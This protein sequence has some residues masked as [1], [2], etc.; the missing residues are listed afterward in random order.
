MDTCYRTAQPGPSRS[1][2]WSGTPLCQQLAGSR[3]DLSALSLSFVQM[4]KL[5]SSEGW[6]LPGRLPGQTVQC[7]T[8]ESLTSFFL[9]G[10]I[11]I[12]Q[13]TK[14]LSGAETITYCSIG[15]TNARNVFCFHITVS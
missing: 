9:R 7:E 4:E 11:E 5:R 1:L 2:T 15:T 14:F 8:L 6:D 13:L 3:S 12:V 10:K